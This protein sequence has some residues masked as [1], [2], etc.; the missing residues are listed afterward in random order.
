MADV[1]SS[2]SDVAPGPRSHPLPD[3]LQA[4][5][6][7]ITPQRRAVIGALDGEH[8][9]LSAEQV[10]A[11]ARRAVPEVSLA[12]VYN[13]LNELADM[14][15]ISRDPAGRRHHPLRPQ[16][17]AGP[18]PPGLRGVRADL[19]RRAQR[20]VRR[21]LAPGRALRHDRRHPRSGVPGPLQ[22]L[23]RARLS[24]GR[25]VQPRWRAAIGSAGGDRAVR[26]RPPAPP[27]RSV[28][29]GPAVDAG[30]EA[31]ITSRISSP[32]SS[33]R[34]S[35]ASR[36]AST[37]WR[38][39][40]SMP[41]HRCLGRGQQVLDLGTAVVVGQDFGDRSRRP[42]TPG[43]PRRPGWCPCP[44]SPTI[45]QAFWVAACRSPATPVEGSPKKISSATMPPKA[46][47]MR[48]R[49]SDLVLVNRSSSRS[50]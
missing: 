28:R 23:R 26:W 21:D 47:S 27:T 12:T 25:G 24:R 20:G 4:R 2:T 7:R 11:A 36:R 39:S 17:R 3:R 16:D 13:T 32:M 9:H 38:C 43:P 18:P 29:A 41:G 1:A 50:G 33:W 44:G 34:S 45:W 5:G 19:R 40:S 48:A 14:G 46:M 42:G 10:H 49:I 37:T 22:Q 15:E 35:R 31:L 6:W 30:C 8:V